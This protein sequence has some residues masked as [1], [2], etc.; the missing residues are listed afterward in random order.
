M[1]PYLP[2]SI[3]LSSP[4]GCGSASLRPPWLNWFELR[5]CFAIFGLDIFA[6]LAD[7]HR[8]LH[9]PPV[10]IRLPGPHFSATHFSVGC[11]YA[12]PPRPEPTEKSG[13]E[14]S[15]LHSVNHPHFVTLTPNSSHRKTARRARARRSDK[16]KPGLDPGTWGTKAALTYSCR[17]AVDSPSPPGI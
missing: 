4:F 17:S 15:T 2:V 13:A 7:N 5:V 16:S 3:F 1:V 8:H 11:L 12:L 14:T 6:F 10:S 9:H